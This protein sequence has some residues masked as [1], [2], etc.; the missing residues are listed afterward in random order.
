M[1]AD[2]EASDLLEDRLFLLLVEKR[3]ISQERIVSLLVKVA[4]P[5]RKFKALVILFKS[6]V[7]QSPLFFFID[8]FGLGDLLYNDKPD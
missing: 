4:D 6:N 1:V 2:V 3:L 5:Y 7:V 8:K